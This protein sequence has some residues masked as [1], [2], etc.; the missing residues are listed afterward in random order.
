MNDDYASRET[1]SAKPIEDISFGEAFRR[2]RNA[3]LDVFTFKGKKF[4]TALAT[5]KKTTP[6]KDVAEAA[7]RRRAAQATAEVAPFQKEMSGTTTG[8]LTDNPR[9]NAYYQGRVNPKTLLPIEEGSA[10]KKGG[11]VKCYAKGGSVS[12]RADGCA[13]KGKTKYKVY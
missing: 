4:T 2:A 13:T 5:P 11:K 6:M 1:P 10:M 3:G 12:S 7:T 8:V 9:S